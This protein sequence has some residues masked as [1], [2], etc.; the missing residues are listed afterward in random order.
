M[1]VFSLQV[2]SAKNKQNQTKNKNWKYEWSVCLL[3]WGT[4][5]HA[6]SKDRLLLPS[7]PSIQRR[8]NTAQCPFYLQC[9]DMFKMASNG[10]RCDLGADHIV[11]EQRDSSMPGLPWSLWLDACPQSHYPKWPL[12]SSGPPYPSMA[13]LHIHCPRMLVSQKQVAL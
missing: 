11:A 7:F 13:F 8:R 6:P 5:W 4:T 10:T 3:T 9:S 12:L 2:H 1:L